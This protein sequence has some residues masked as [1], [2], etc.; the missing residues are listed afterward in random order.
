[1]AKRGERWVVKAGSSLIAGNDKGLDR[2][3]IKAL[4][5]QIN[6]LLQKEIEIIVVSSGAIAKGIFEL[7]MLERPSNLAL[8]QASAA[9]GQLGLINSYQE[10][11]NKYNIKTAQVLISHDDI[12]NRHR[13][14]NSRNSLITLLNLGVVPIV[15]EN[16]SVA[17]EEITFGDNDMLAGALTGLIQATRLVI[18]TDQKGICDSNPTTNKNSKLLREIDL[19]RDKSELKRLVQSS[20]GILGRGGI[21]TKLDASRLALD[22]GVEVI[23]ADGRKHDT[24]ISIF[25]EKE[26]GTSVISQSRHLT[27]RKKWIASLGTPSGKLI[28]DEGAVTAITKKGSSLLPVGITNIEKEFERG[29]L[30]SCRDKTGSEIARGLTNFNSKELKKILGLNSKK[31]A[32]ELGYPT[33]EEVIHRDNLILR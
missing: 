8:L 7:D 27:S 25:D 9:V 29:D 3:F 20:S 1:M 32:E 18:L 10:E 23:V 19:E 15:N 11:F 5:Y 17:T 6:H 4:A 31:I 12:V 26:I 30:L 14:L 28:L 2:S 22:F 24:L 13:Y 33:D 16:D 21:K